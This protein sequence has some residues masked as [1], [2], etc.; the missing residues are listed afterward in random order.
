MRT[1]T[2]KTPEQEFRCDRKSWCV[3]LEGHVDD[4]EPAKPSRLYEPATPLDSALVLAVHCARC[5]ASASVRCAGSINEPVA[6]HFARF[7]QANVMPPEHA[8][9]DRKDLCPFHR[10]HSK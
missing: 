1:H 10:R 9:Y 5:R 8:T 6:F 2:M 4:C 7:M 3:R